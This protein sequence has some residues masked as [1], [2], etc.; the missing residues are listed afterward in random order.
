[1]AEDADFGSVRLAINVRAKSAT[2]RPQGSYI[3]PPDESLDACGRQDWSCYNTSY[4]DGER[5]VETRA[6]R[7]AALEED[8]AALL[9]KHLG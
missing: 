5:V 8:L 4:K 9:K 7:M 2:C 1:M 6:A 3:C